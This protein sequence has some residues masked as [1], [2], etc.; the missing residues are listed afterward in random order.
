MSASPIDP[1]AP[2]EEQDEGPTGEQMSFTE[3]ALANLLTGPFDKVSITIPAALKARIAAR[4]IDMNFSAYVTEVLE[5][6]ERRRSLLDFLDY[7]DELHGP[8]SKEQ[9]AEADRRWEEMW[10]GYESSEASS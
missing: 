1:S 6:E 4:A 7:M 8:P 2:G 3:Q 10:E 9:I 5:R